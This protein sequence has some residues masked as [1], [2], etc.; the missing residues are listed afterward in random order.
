MSLFGDEMDDEEEGS[1]PFAEEQ[2]PASALLPPRETVQAFGFDKFEQQILGLIAANKM[3]HALIFAGPEGIGKATFAFRLARFLL[4]HGDLDSSQDS[5][6]GDAPSLPATFDVPADDPV[7]RRVASGG[8]PDL[9]V[10]E[11]Q[12]DERKSNAL[13]KNLDADTIRKITPFL[14][15]TA[16]EGGWRV[17]IVDDAETMSLTAQDSLLK[18]LEEPPPRSLLILITARI[19]AFKP[20]IRSR[21]RVLTFTPPE[22]D[23]FN[24]L[25]MAADPS[26][27]PNNLALLHSLSNGSPGRALALVEEGGVEMVQSVLAPFDDWPQMDMVKIHQLAENIGRFGNDNGWAV[28]QTLTLWL[29]QSLAFAGAKGGDALPLALRRSPFPQMLGSYDMLALANAY[30][31]AREFLSQTD[32]ANLDRRQAVLSIYGLW[33]A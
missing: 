30:D 18:I 2:A 1:F 25:V 11:R 10:A 4:K 26:L 20:T 32:H 17:V 27:T 3:P 28:F 13:R 23:V 12:Q 8:H 31:K 33:A 14:R 29:F 6:F 21:C 22:E 24:K 16:S 5:L 7:F 9:M 15:M 19:G